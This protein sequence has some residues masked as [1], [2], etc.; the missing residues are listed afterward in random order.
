MLVDDNDDLRRYVCETLSRSFT[1]VEVLDGQAA[2]EYARKWPPSLIVSDVQMPRLNGFGLL[3][4]I[5][6]DARTSAIP[7]IFLSALATTEARSAALEQGA[8][9][10]VVKP[11]QSREL[12]ARVTVHLQLAKLREALERRG[13]CGAVR[14]SD[15]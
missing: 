3:S 10:Y 8:D 11:F 2:L 5:R 15:C 9:D 4:A 6:A 13:D 7:V 12:L 1:V 14:A